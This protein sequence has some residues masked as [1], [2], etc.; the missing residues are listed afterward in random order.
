MPENIDNIRKC[1]DC[2]CAFALDIKTFSQKCKPCTK[3]TG[4]MQY[5][6]R[7]LSKKVAPAVPSIAN[8]TPEQLLALKKQLDALS[9]ASKNVAEEKPAKKTKE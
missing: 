9:E 5:S 3:K 6:H 1:L 2:G 4:S 7:D 8:L